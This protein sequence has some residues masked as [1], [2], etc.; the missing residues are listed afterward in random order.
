MD[1]RVITRNPRYSVVRREGGLWQLTIKDVKPSDQGW[2][3]CQINTEPMMSEK[4]F[5]EVT[6]KDICKSFSLPFSF[7]VLE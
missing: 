2:Y 5:L 4:G 1:E 6:G 3:M 7:I